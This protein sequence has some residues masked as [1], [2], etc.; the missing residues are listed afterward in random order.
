MNLIRRL[1]MSFMPE[2][3]KAKRIEWY[4]SLVLPVCNG[5]YKFTMNK[6]LHIEALSHYLTFN[7]AYLLL[8]KYGYVKR[9]NYINKHG[10]Q[11]YY[12]ADMFKAD[13]LFRML[14]AEGKIKVPNGY[15]DYVIGFN[16][17]G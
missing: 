14:I 16:V 6:P 10:E 3:K 13:H 5:P 11:G 17:N 12:V 2:N 4:Q 15:E 8:E 1:V 7:E 9:C